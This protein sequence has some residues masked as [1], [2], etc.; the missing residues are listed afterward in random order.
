MK[1]SHDTTNTNRGSDLTRLLTSRSKLAVIVFIFGIAILLF[2]DFFLH[3]KPPFPGNYL[4][5]WYEPWKSL[6]LDG[7]RILLPHKPIAEDIFRH[8]VPFRLLG[9]DLMKQLQPP[10]WN[11]YNGS[12][13]PLLATINSGF[14]D[15][16]NVLFFLFPLAIAYGLYIVIQFMLISAGTYLYSRTIGLTKA[17]SLVTTLTFVLSGFVTIRLIYTIYG[18]SLAILPFMLYLIEAYRR[19]PKTRA[20]LLIPFLVFVMTVSTQTQIVIYILSVISIYALLRLFGQSA[21]LPE[22]SRKAIHIFMLFILG[23]GLAAV[24]LAPTY[25]LMQLSHIS[26]QNSSEVIDKFLV[27]VQHLL[28]ILIPNFFGSLATY[29]YWGFSDYIQTIAHVGIVPVFLAVLALAGKG[30]QKNRFHVLFFAGLTTV[31]CMLAVDWP[32]SRLF[33]T[34][35]IPII[36]TGAPSR[37]FLLSTFGI[38]MLAGFGFDR[39]RA[40]PIKNRSFLLTSLIFIFSAASLVGIVYYAYRSG[41]VCDYGVIRDCWRVTF[42]NTA[43]AVGAF[44]VQLCVLVCMILRKR[45]RLFYGFVAAFFIIFTLPALYNARKVLPRTPTTDLFPQLPVIT[46]LQRHTTDARVFGIGHATLAT[47]L[48]TQLRIYDPQFY[49]PLYI[50]RYREL[51]EYA[52]NGFAAP[53]FPR[54]D[55]SI[56]HFYDVDDALIYRRNRLLDLDSV[57]YRLYKKGEVTATPA[58]NLIW[59]DDTWLLL[60]TESALPRAY[61]P[62]RVMTAQTDEEILSTLFDPSFDIHN[63]ALV[64]QHLDID[65]SDDPATGTATIIHYGANRV[66][67]S[68]DTER[69][70]VLVLTDNYYPGWKAFINGKEKS[71]FRANYAFRAVAVPSGTNTVSFLYQPDSFRNGLVISFV[72]FML[73]IILHVHAFSVFR[74][75][76]EH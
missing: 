51:L 2:S 27:P 72:S 26:P 6:H 43:F 49:H 20:I 12:G 10:L 47:D 28:T 15:P 24:Q 61:L 52:N 18:T 21:P 37:I 29:N 35:P 74:K 23:I 55:A 14:L 40:L 62:A 64:E 56:K 48:A 25:E 58:G 66:E 67:V 70:A 3:G 46:A 22:R 30:I 17:A 41:Y 50:L 36:S 8:L 38:S 71:I 76:A 59:E 57:K 54:G 32:V 42:R 5:A 60:A 16:F 69:D 9:V 11:P 45:T 13:M 39:L 31:A 33:Y 63:S 19:D 53:Q 7:E 1:K 75:S 4:Q 34:I 44:G 68:V 73:V 65:V